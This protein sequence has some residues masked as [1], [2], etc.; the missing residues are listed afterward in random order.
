MTIDKAINRLYWR[1]GGNGN[2]NPFP[3]NKEDAEALNTIIRTVNDLKKGLFDTNRGFAKMYIFALAYF[4]KRY[5]TDIFDPIPQKELSRMLD[6]DLSD[7][8]Q[9]FT[10]NLNDSDRYRS[11]ESLIGETSHPMLM[12]EDKKKQRLAKLREEI[13]KDPSKL[14]GITGNAWRYEDV[15]ESLMQM[16]STALIRFKL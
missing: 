14:D 4:V 5:D 10:D 8:V 11:L 7:F 6:R 15:E 13:K 12:D 16:V 1:F 9:R 3:V 2:K